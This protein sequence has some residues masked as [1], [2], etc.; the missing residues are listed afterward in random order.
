MNKINKLLSF[1]LG[2]ILFGCQQ[3]KI[4]KTET[5]PWVETVATIISSPNITEGS[6]D[7]LIK[8]EAS[9]GTAVNKEGKKINGMIEQF[10]LSQKRPLNKQKLRLRYMKEEPVIFELMDRIKFE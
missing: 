9:E 1:V 5:S 4:L 3:Q 7:Y 10:G 8:Y 6:Y 2:I